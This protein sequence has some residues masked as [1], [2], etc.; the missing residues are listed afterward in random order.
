MI[1]KLWRYNILL[2]INHI[3]IFRNKLKSFSYQNIIKI[4][5]KNLLEDNIYPTPAECKAVAEVA[6][7]Q[8]DK[9]FYSSLGPKRWEMFYVRSVRKYVNIIR[10]IPK[11]I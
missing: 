10:I 1:E 7:Q 4:G 5:A 3:E 6:F 8:N 11:F 2:I 9:E